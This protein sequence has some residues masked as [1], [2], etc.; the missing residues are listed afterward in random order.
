MSMQRIRAVVTVEERYF[1]TNL[2]PGSTRDDIPLKLVR[3]HWAVENRGNWTMDTIWAEDKRPWAGGALEAVSLLRLMAVN[4]I[5]R[6]RCRRFRSAR[7]RSRPWR[8][9]LSWV[10]DVLLQDGVAW[11]AAPAQQPEGVAAFE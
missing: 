7:N 2:P 9:L 4:V 11:L 8:I 5:T 3:A 6:L 10:S 1:V